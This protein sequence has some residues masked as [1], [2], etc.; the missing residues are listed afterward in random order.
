MIL[1]RLISWP[2]FRR[3]VLRTMLTVAGIVLG[4]AV[5]VGMH[6]ANQSVLFA[7]SRTVDRIAGKTELQVTAGETGFDEDVLEKVQAASTVRVAVPVIEAVVDTKIAGEGSLLV[8]GVDMT[9]DRSLRDYDLDSG[10]EAVIDDPLVFLAQPDSIILT[11]D[12]AEKN[13]LATLSQVPL[14]TVEGEKRFTVRGIM[15][16]SGLT[17][18]FGGNLAIMDIYAAQRMFGRGRKFDRIDL[19]VKPGRTIGECEHEL[20]ALLGPGFQVEPP[21]G[22]G[23]QFEAM[24]AAYSMM[25][26]ISSLFALFI[27]MFIIYN[28]FAIA[29][30]ERR[31]EIGI[32]RALGATRTQIRWLFLGESAVTGLIGS[33]GGLLFG[34]LIAHGIAASIGSLINDVYGVAQRA[35]ELATSPAL[36]AVALGIGIATSI[37][38]ALIPARNAARVDP[39]QALQKGKYQ[40]LSA[41]ESRLRVVLAVLLGAVSIVCLLVPSGGEGLVPGGVENAARSSRT[42]FYTGYFLMVV[43]ALLLSPLLSLALA[44]ALRPVLKWLR[45]VEGALAAHSLIQAPRRT[46]AS[47]AALMLSL[48]L[49]VAFAGVARA[50]YA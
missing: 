2:Y 13:G 39:V 30:T 32:L 4:V 26:N 33:L 20:Q 6:T 29:V 9:G 17:S 49:V 14:G 10:D 24:L 42:I 44:R 21:S 50:S 34:I 27:G 12:F 31:S 8:L 19:A 40:V 47:V 18:A 1:L 5:F 7:F 16:S 23:R 41:G 36:L 38:A 35:D 48:A 22:R 46:S 45:P 43:V 15:K 11:R 28:S 37:V 3:H 25:V